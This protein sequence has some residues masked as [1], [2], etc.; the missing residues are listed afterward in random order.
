MREQD[1]CQHST[2]NGRKRMERIR[3]K[4]TI[5]FKTIKFLF[6]ESL[7]GNDLN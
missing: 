5:I 7:N 1:A 3:I 2:G 6:K 4:T